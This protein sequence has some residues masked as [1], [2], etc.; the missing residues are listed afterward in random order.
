MTESA[1]RPTAGAD[2]SGG[3]PGPGRARGSHDV[4]ATYDALAPI[5]DVVA[6]PF[7]WPVVRAGLELLAAGPG[8]RVLEV[9]HG[10]GRAL[11]ALARAVGDG[12]RVLGV[13]LSPRMGE[14]A[15]RRLSRAGLGEKV[16]LRTADATALALE[17]GT[18][19]AVF[20]AFMVETLPEADVPRVLASWRAA[21][22]PGGRLVLVTMAPGGGAM[23]RLYGWSHRAF[24]QWVD[25]R[26]L[27]ARPLVE[28]A[29][30]VVDRDDRVPLA[31]IPAAVTR[32]LRA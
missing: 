24:P 13:D 6:A 31:G 30:F 27:E 26:P 22:R 25:C 11:V 3:G 10:T 28:A 2:S 15:R 16:E 12:G 29:G 5:Y 9:G 32:G 17:P 21:L 14:G 1:G 7:E 19:D 18:F 8:E 23:A 20:S 4:R